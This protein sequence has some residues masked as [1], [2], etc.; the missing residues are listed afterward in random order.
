MELNCIAHVDAT[1]GKK[2]AD[3]RRAFLSPTPLGETSL[4]EFMGEARK[5]SNASICTSCTQRLKHHGET[6]KANLPDG[7]VRTEAAS[8]EDSQ[9]GRSE[10]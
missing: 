3:A 7:R 5:V 8:G 4:Q 10:D 2:I 6:W 9:S 1:R